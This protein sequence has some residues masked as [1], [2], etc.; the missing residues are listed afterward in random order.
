M[1]PSLLLTHGHWAALAGLALLV[2]LGWRV[3][4]RRGATSGTARRLIGAALAGSLAIAVAG[5]Y[6]WWCLTQARGSAPHPPWIIELGALTPQRHR[7]ILAEFESV[8]SRG[9]AQLP[10]GC[11]YTC[12]ERK[13]VE[14]R[15]VERL[16]ALSRATGICDAGPLVPLAVLDPAH[17]QRVAERMLECGPS[18]GLRS[19]ALERLAD[20]DFELASDLYQNAAY[21]YV[22]QPPNAEWGALRSEVLVHWLARRGQRAA[23]ALGRARHLTDDQQRRVDC[24]RD[25]LTVVIK[26]VGTDAASARLRAAR[27][28]DATCALIA[29]NVWPEE[30]QDVLATLD[31]DRLRPNAR[32]IRAALMRSTNAPPGCPTADYDYGGLA[33]WDLLPAATLL[34]MRR[35]PEAQGHTKSDALEDEHCAAIAAAQLGDRWQA[36]ASLTRSRATD[37][38]DM[39]RT[40]LYSVDEA[41]LDLLEG[42]PLAAQA[43]LG[44]ERHPGAPIDRTRIPALVQ[45]ALRKTKEPPLPNLDA[46]HC[47]RIGCILAAVDTKQRPELERRLRRELHQARLEPNPERRLFALSWA[48]WLAIAL[49]DQELA[50]SAEASQEKVKDMEPGLSAVLALLE[51]GPDGLQTG[52]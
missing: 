48:R 28:L 10:E 12:P 30:M 31:P 6:G 46:E 4:G 49:G 33:F 40:G 34:P 47:S 1:R 51:A 9:R 3:A 39:W 21:L 13:P 27:E 26:G 20:E 36:R 19:L 25:A 16:I 35:A 23:D 17:T 29:A 2:W 43:E 42:R 52:N 11:L 44:P 37:E 24:A 5:G 14:Q 32:A 7:I 15:L 8:R 41:A 18:P 50:L 38:L 22:I 45:F